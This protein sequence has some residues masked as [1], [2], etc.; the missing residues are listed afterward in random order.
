MPSCR[1]CDSSL[2]TAHPGMY[3]STS[4]RRQCPVAQ[5][6][7]A[8]QLVPHATT[9][10]TV[11]LPTERSRPH[12][13]RQLVNDL[14]NTTHGQLIP[15][16][17][18]CNDN[19]NSRQLRAQS[20]K[21]PDQ[22]HNK[23]TTASQI[24]F[25]TDSQH[26]TKSEQSMHYQMKLWWFKADPNQGVSQTHGEGLHPTWLG[27]VEHI[28]NQRVCWHNILNMQHF[29]S[30]DAC[31]SFHCCNCSKAHSTSGFLPTHH[32][33]PAPGPLPQLAAVPLLTI[34]F[35]HQHSHHPNP[36]A[37]VQN[38]PCAGQTFPVPAAH[39]SSLQGGSA[40]LAGPVHNP[41]GHRD[42]QHE[43]G[44]Q[45]ANSLPKGQA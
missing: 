18:C 19:H 31:A 8:G 22:I 33:C 28:N 43:V 24:K 38:Q 41:V 4:N 30:V 35:Q 13:Y 25:T 16:C 40:P 45:D 36:S 7:L 14:F 44:Q 27:C 26:R 21:L 42:K 37:N 32:T 2:V 6:C 23:L 12:T 20:I 39:N 11:R 1:Q 5:R 10:Q 29:F 34:G 17:W 3:Q 9:T 15:S